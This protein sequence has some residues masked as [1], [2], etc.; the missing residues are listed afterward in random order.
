MSLGLLIS[1]AFWSLVA[2]LYCAAHDGSNLMLAILAGI[3][4]ASAAVAWVKMQTLTV[5]G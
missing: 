5:E 1:L 4:A 3:S 2:A